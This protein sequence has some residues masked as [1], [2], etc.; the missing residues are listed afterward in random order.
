MD[1]DST[2]E[3]TFTEQGP[4]NPVP[5]GVEG[6]RAGPPRPSASDCPALLVEPQARV[7]DQATGLSFDPFKRSNKISRSPPTRTR[8]G[9]L[10]VELESI[11]CVS[12]NISKST[13]ASDI[14]KPNIKEK[15][16]KISKSTPDGVTEQTDKK[17]KLDN[18]EENTNHSLVPQDDGEKLERLRNIISELRAT[19]E[20]VPNTKGVIKKGIEDIYYIV[21]S[22]G[23]KDVE[24][25]RKKD[26]AINTETANREMGTQTEAITTENEEDPSDENQAKEQIWKRMEEEE[27]YDTFEE[28]AWRDWPKSTYRKVRT[29]TGNP[30]KVAPDWDLAFCMTESTN[31][32]KGL[33]KVLKEKYSALVDAETPQDG[34]VTCYTAAST[35][36]V[37]GRPPITG[38]RQL[39][40]LSL[41]TSPN[42]IESTRSLYFSLQNLRKIALDDK[43]DKMAITFLDFPDLELA[44]KATEY[45]FINTNVDIVMYIQS[46]KLVPKT[47]DGLVSK[48]HQ[49]SK[50]TEKETMIVKAEG[51]SYADLL[52]EVKLKV[53]PGEIGVVV[54]EMRKTKKGDMLLTLD[55]GEG[56]HK[57]KAEILNE[58]Q[59][60][61]VSDIREREKTL[62]VIDLDAVTTEEE[63]RNNIAGQFQIPGEEILVK[64]IR[65]TSIGK[66]IATVVVKQKIAQKILEVGRVKI[67]WINCRIKERVVI[68]RCYRCLNFGHE[69]RNCQGP[70][71]ENICL[72]C[73]GEGHKVA[74][75][76]NEEYCCI[77][78]K[79]GHKGGSI[80]CPEYK[81]ILRS[82]VKQRKH[83][84]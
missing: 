10:G 73:G 14:T 4:G 65:P 50:R 25:K 55:R 54:R 38:R 16:S 71:R 81:K 51:R 40:K 29:E 45:I 58:V 80:K 52:R 32:E 15:F 64:N 56:T 75:C 62:H 35:L 44:K 68:Q 20:G 69:A 67:G 18:R 36:T 82:T 37:P 26:K 33:A 6:E 27:S 83:R 43:K 70:N 79:A 41:K 63:V 12:K 9:S 39:L 78:S 74:D 60:A 61:S 21:E 2:K 49:R 84:S 34:S 76:S 5:V 1:M 53:N 66:Q 3:Y 30:E 7:L 11:C 19:I 46:E 17:R 23:R 31:M 77:C 22:L 28:L 59:G 47:T 24:T 48:Y 13:S 42:T 8:T 72:K 57:L